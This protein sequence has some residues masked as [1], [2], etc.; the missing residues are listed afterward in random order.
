[1]RTPNLL[2]CWPDTARSW[3]GHADVGLREGLREEEQLGEG[4][5]GLPIQGRG[6]RRC[7][8]EARLGAMT[9][10]LNFIQ[11]RIFRIRLLMLQCGAGVGRQP[12]LCC[13]T[14]G[15]GRRDGRKVW[16]L[17]WSG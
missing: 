16:I 9:E 17:G 3:V 15:L 7:W 8:D 11:N 1:M 5:Q 6:R 4:P 12:G 14:E 10:N 13:Q 2:L